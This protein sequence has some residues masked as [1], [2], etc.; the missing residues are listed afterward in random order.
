[1]IQQLEEE[2]GCDAESLDSGLLVLDQEEQQ[3]ALAWAERFATK[4]EL[5]TPEQ[6]QQLEPALAS[7]SNNG[8]W[9]PEVGQVR[10]PRLIQT[11]HRAA[12][13]AGLTILEHHP[14]QQLLTEQGNVIGVT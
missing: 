11:L 2:S 9:M 1:M 5:V 14:V 10:N 7:Q 12:L 13:E 6:I 8:L 3:Q 4:V